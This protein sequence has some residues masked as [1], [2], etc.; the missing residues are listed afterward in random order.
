M[1]LGHIKMDGIDPSN[2]LEPGT[3]RTTRGVPPPRLRSTPG[4]H[5]GGIGDKVELLSPGSGDDRDLPS[6]GSPTEIK[7]ELSTLL[8]PVLDVSTS[9]GEEDYEETPVTAGRHL[10]LLWRGKGSPFAPTA[11]SVSSDDSEDDSIEERNRRL[12]NVRQEVERYKGKHRGGNGER[13]ELHSPGSGEDEELPSIGGSPLIKVELSTL[14]SPASDVSTS[15]GEGNL[16]DESVDVRN[17]RLIKDCQEDKYLVWRGSDCCPEPTDIQPEQGQEET[18]QLQAF[19]NVQGNHGKAPSINEEGAEPFHFPVRDGDHLHPPPLG[20]SS[21][22]GDKDDLPQGEVQQVA[23]RINTQAGFKTRMK[24]ELNQIRISID[25]YSAYHDRIPDS[26]T[27]VEMV[28]RNL[29][30]RLAVLKGKAVQSDD[31]KLIGLVSTMISVLAAARDKWMERAVQHAGDDVQPEQGQEEAEQLQVFNNVQ[32]NYGKAPSLNKEG[33][34]PS[35]L[36]VRDGD[37]L[38][39]PPPGHN[40]GGGAEQLQVFNNVQGNYGK[41]PPPP[42]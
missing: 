23:V 35:H 36:P 17:R 10:Q 30:S 26:R 31:L 20:H 32:G 15:P 33:A 28:A 40:S 42:Q 3:T 38:H 37:H 12:I 2:I 24:A 7:V 16:E 27:L 39:P 41:A 34:E 13:K 14:L 29:G 11:R 21:G 8:S 19:N 18:G 1:S 4:K 5:R 9:P 6:T 25:E 22:G